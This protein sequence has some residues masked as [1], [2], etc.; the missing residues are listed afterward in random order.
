[1]L[2]RVP[3]G[4]PSGVT[5][6]QDHEGF[7]VVVRRAYQSCERAVQDQIARLTSDEPTNGNASG[8]GAYAATGVL[9]DRRGR[10][11]AGAQA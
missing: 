4:G 1:M 10:I 5:C 8:N 7:Q 3:A 6:C 2:C 11:A 9:D